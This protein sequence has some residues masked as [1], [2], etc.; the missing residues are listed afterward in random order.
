MLL[1]ALCF[2]GGCSREQQDWRAAESTDT[3]GSYGRFIEQHPESELVTQARTRMTQLGE[4]RDWKRAGSADTAAAYQEFLGQHPSGKWAQEARI[5]VQNFAL[6]IAAQ[7]LQSPPVA[8]EAVPPQSSTM[9]R[10]ATSPPASAVPV[11]AAEGFSIQLG[12]FSSEDR[13]H[14]EWQALQGRFPPQLQGLTPQVVA[15]DTASGRVYRLQAR[16]ADEARARLICA[17]LRTQSQ[18]CVPVVPH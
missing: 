11:A 3:L 6:G 1:A 10:T 12:A 5:R 7:P 13:A 15:A 4:D 16:A 9:A 8:G 14:A 18:G 17:E 2:M